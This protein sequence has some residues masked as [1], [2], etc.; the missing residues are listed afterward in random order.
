MKTKMSEEWFLVQ[1]GTGNR[2]SLPREVCHRLDVKP[3]RYVVLNVLAC[4]DTQAQAFMKAL[5]G[6]SGKKLEKVK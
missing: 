3:G 4:G 6:K 2:I 5:E 1:V